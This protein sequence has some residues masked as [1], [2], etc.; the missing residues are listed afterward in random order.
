MAFRHVRDSWLKR[1][2]D[3]RTLL[4]RAAGIFGLSATAR[5]SGA[6]RQTATFS[7]FPFTLGVASGDPTET[8]VVL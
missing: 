1:R 5:I 3:R 2:V 8:G 6:T 7:S 4:A